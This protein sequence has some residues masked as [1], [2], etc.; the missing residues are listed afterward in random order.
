M[1]RGRVEAF[2]D[3][4]MAV[5]ITLLVLDLHTS[6]ATGEP[7][8]D[9]L[10]HEWPAF[11]AYLL[12][13]FVIGT[14]WVNHHL[15]FDAMVR[16]DRLT[17]AL[18]LLLLLFVCTIPF[19]TSTLA[20]F[21]VEGGTNAQVAV[22]LYGAV[23]EGMA[24]SFVLI[25]RHIIDAGLV[26]RPIGRDERRRQLVRFGAGLVLYPL[27]TVVGLFAPVVMMVGLTVLSIYYLVGRSA[28]TELAAPSPE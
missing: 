2:S 24:V 3:G 20:D 6:A 9:Q 19:S 8:L 14:I 7:L 5:A 16:V 1:G 18:N 10:A 15:L 27:A 25:L 12:S 22:V 13:F 26:S 23:A 28:L 11:L 21:V 17:L 4:V